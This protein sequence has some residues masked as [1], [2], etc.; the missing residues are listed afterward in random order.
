MKYRIFIHKHSAIKVFYQ[1]FNLT[2]RRNILFV[3]D[4]KL[5]QGSLATHKQNILVKIN[6]VRMHLAK[7]SSISQ[8]L[9]NHVKLVLDPH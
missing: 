7:G 5:S 1:T 8:T 2:E 6:D 9:N 4:L 3:R